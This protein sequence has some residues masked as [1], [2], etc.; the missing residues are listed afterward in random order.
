MPYIPS[1]RRKYIGSI[2]NTDRWQKFLNRPGDVF[3]CTPPKC[4]TT[5]TTTIVAMLV[6]GST[7]VDTQSLVQWVD[8]EVVA[9]DE[10]MGALATQN[11]RRCI[12]THTPLMVSPGTLMPPT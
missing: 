11:H 10:V 9:I 4:G 7:D 6:S 3:V 2:T 1:K 8:A 5:W 12:K